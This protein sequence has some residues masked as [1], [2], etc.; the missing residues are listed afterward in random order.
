M[1]SA[2]AKW[3]AG[4]MKCSRDTAR[5]AARVCARLFLN[6]A[7]ALGIWAFAGCLRFA[8]DAPEDAGVPSGFDVVSPAGTGADPAPSAPDAAGDASPGPIC[9]RFD[10][11]VTDAVSND[12]TTALLR[13]CRVNAYFTALPPV[14]LARFA[15]C[16]AAQLASVLGCVRPDGERYKYPAYDPEGEFCRDMKTAHANLAASDG[17]FDAFSDDLRPV[18]EMH[19]FTEDETARVLKVF[20]AT[21]VDIVQRHDAGPTRAC[22]AGR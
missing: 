7:L 2:F 9:Q 19:G 22:D 16:F 11:S 1:Q 13:D 4:R 10:P 14:R 17:D 21:R 8:D 15:E 3:R 5:Y 6:Q 20:G 18:L 12:L